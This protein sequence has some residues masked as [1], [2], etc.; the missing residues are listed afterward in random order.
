MGRGGGAATTWPGVSAGESAGERPASADPAVLYASDL[1]KLA[2]VPLSVR[3][4]RHILRGIFPPGWAEV[5]ALAE[6]ALSELMT[7]A[8]TISQLW[9]TRTLRRAPA[10]A[11]RVSAQGRYLYVDVR[12]GVPWP[13]V[14]NPRLP[15]P[16]AIGGRGLYL[17]SEQVDALYVITDPPGK[18][19]TARLAIGQ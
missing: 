2:A 19:V 4:A 1:Y 9:A 6:L 14:L 15:P 8:V 13:L 11:F 10:V 5:A 16:G 3:E 12:D 7:N 18:V 17:L